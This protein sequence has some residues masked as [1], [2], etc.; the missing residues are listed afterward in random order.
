MQH[1]CSEKKLEI[2]YRQERKYLSRLN[3]YMQEHIT[4]M[5]V[6]QIFGKEKVEFKKIFRN[7][8]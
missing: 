8:F 2:A 4:G 1:S 5:N 7:K 6:V 3:S